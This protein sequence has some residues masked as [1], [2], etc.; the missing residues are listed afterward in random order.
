L[1]TTRITA[2]C[3]IRN[4]EEDAVKSADRTKVVIAFEYMVFDTLVQ[5][6][7]SLFLL[8]DGWMD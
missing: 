3:G 5:V 6:N 4:A 8:T 2:G 1:D 7:N